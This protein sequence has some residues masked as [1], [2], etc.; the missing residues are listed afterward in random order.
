[1]D[2]RFT[3][4]GK[5]FQQQFTDIYQSRLALLSAV[6]PVSVGRDAPR[7]GKDCVMVL[8]SRISTQVGILYKDM[9][10]KPN[11]LN[12]YT[13]VGFLCLTPNRRRNPLQP[14]SR[15]KRTSSRWRIPLEGSS[16]SACLLTNTS[17]VSYASDKKAGMVVGVFGDEE[18]GELRVTKL[19]LPTYA[20]PPPLP[21]SE[22]RY[23]A[24]LSGLQIGRPKVGRGVSLVVS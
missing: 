10:N 17:Q 4:K 8:L 19:L 14:L 13:D 12:E 3:V 1:M 15:V 7:S 9:K 24:M 22:D 16:L 5:Q 18:G 20:P 2:A 23:V 6:I 11:I 21:A